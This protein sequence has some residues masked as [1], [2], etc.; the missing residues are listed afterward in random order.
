[1]GKEA[2]KG[3]RVKVHARHSSGRIVNCSDI[4]TAIGVVSGLFPGRNV[5]VCIYNLGFRSASM[6][7]GKRVLDHL[8]A[9]PQKGRTTAD[10]VQLFGRVNGYVLDALAEAG[11]ENGPRLM[12]VKEVSWI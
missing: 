4:S 1:M 3:T 7:S 12:C 2:K 11:F 8:I 9:L 6:R 5:L 10:L